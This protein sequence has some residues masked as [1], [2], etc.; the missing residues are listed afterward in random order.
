[1]SDLSDGLLQVG[2]DVTVQR[3]LAWIMVSIWQLQNGMKLFQ[4]KWK[5][6]LRERLVFLYILFV[7]S[8]F[9]LIWTFANASLISS[10]H[11]YAIL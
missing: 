1:M 10:F 3:N 5:S 6:W 4:K 8:R 7:V 2:D 9:L 11:V